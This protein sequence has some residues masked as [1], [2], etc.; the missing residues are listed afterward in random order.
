[1]G[2]VLASGSPRRRMLLESIGVALAAV[3]PPRIDERRAP[4]ETAVDYVRRL[5]V[6]KAAA[7][8]AAGHWVLAADT[9]VHRD[10]LV[11]EKPTDEAD[12]RR[13]LR[14]LSGGWHRVSTGWCLRQD[15][16]DPAP[17]TVAVVSSR[18]RFRALSDA[19]IA[20]YVEMGES[21]DKAGAYGIQGMGAALVAEVAGS[22][23]NVVG[24]P[25]DDVVPALRGAGILPPLSP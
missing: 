19:E 10:G 3:R 12:A 22:H 17:S 7:V 4:G 5:A 11:L 1:M 24:L 23:S 2:L 20:A 21:L 9:T 13:M 25:L 6:E 18:V 16:P 14:R 8:S 15:A